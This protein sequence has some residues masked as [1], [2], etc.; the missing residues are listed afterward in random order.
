[1]GSWTVTAGHTAGTGAAGRV[2]ARRR[3]WSA[4]M[5]QAFMP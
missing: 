5:I 2:C 3:Q 4:I 1:M